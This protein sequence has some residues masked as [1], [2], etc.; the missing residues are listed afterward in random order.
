MNMTYTGT[1]SVWDFNR[2]RGWISCPPLDSFYVHRANV[3]ADERGFQSLQV[4]EIVEFELGAGYGKNKDKIQ[5]IH[6][7]RVNV[8]VSAPA[9]KVQE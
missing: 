7:R 1:V 9:P 8:P 5:A 2:A 6:V 4:G 3:I